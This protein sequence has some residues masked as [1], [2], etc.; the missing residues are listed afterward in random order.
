MSC[1]LADA[2]MGARHDTIVL[3]FGLTTGSVQ[4]K[5]RTYMRRICIWQLL[6]KQKETTVAKTVKKVRRDVAQARQGIKDPEPPKEFTS[7]LVCLMNSRSV[8][9]P[10]PGRQHH[11]RAPTTAT[12]RLSPLEIPATIALQRPFQDAPCAKNTSIYREDSS[13]SENKV[14]MEP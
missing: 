1:K 2:S 4:G 13:P 5:E 10:T 9:L 14:G 8:G 12:S 6:F 11:K 7:K 3:G